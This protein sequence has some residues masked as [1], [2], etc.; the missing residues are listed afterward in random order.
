MMYIAFSLC[1]AILAAGKAGRLA[2]AKVASVVLTT[3]LVLV[4]VPLC[5]ARFAN[6]GLGVMY[7]MV[8]GELLTLVATASSSAKLST[9]A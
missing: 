4:L 6:G 1:T 2:S 7:A 9:L 8:I 5:Q 3:G